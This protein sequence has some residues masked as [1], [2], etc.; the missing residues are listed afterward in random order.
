MVSKVY[1]NSI[2]AW[3]LKCSFNKVVI[4]E[5]SETAN[6][7]ERLFTELNNECSSQ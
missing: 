1:G 2:K 7:L 5:G 6:E 4:E 3:S